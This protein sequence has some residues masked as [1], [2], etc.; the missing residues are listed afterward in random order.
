[1]THHQQLRLRL[2]RK[3][4]L[5]HYL[6]QLPWHGGGPFTLTPVEC[7]TGVGVNRCVGHTIEVGQLATVAS[8][9]AFGVSGGNT[10]VMTI[11]I[12]VRNCVVLVPFV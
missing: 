4:S 10:Q 1:M 8:T 2:S 6:H 5:C 11:E 9:L 7:P 12:P 3:L